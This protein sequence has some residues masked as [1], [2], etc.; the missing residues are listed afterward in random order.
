MGVMLKGRF[1]RKKLEHFNIISFGKYKAFSGCWF[2]DK[3]VFLNGYP[4]RFSAH[5]FGERRQ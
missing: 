3:A 4:F 2:E 5:K 1:T